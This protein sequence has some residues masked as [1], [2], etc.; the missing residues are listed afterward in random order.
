[1]H[2]RYRIA[3]VILPLAASFLSPAAPALAATAVPDLSISKVADP[4]PVGVGQTITYTITIVNPGPETVTGVEGLDFL[5]PEVDFVSAMDSVGSDCFHDGQFARC[6]IGSMPPGTITMT[7]VGTVTQ[8]PSDGSL[9]NFCTVF[10][11]N[12]PDPSNN[13]F[14][15]ETSVVETVLE[16]EK[17]DSEDPVEQGAELTYTITVRNVGTETAE[18]V[19][20]VDMLPDKVTFVAAAGC[21]SDGLPTVECEAGDMPPGSTAFFQVVVTVAPDATGTIENIVQAAGRNTNIAQASEPTTIGPCIPEGALTD[22]DIMEN[23]LDKMVEQQQ[24]GGGMTK[25][26]VKQNTKFVEGVKKDMLGE[27]FPDVFGA[28][29]DLVFIFLE[30][31]DTSME[32]ARRLADNQFHDVAKDF[33]RARARVRALRSMLEGS[34]APEGVFTDLDVMENKLDKMIRKQEQGDGMTKEKVKQ[35]TKFVEDVKE[36]MLGEHFSDVCGAPFDLVFIF[37]EQIDTAMER[38]RRLADNQFHDVAKDFE[39]ARARVRALRG[40]LE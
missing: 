40:L 37:L 14:E 16:I 7:V 35:N 21:N 23:K 26:K 24:R 29:F 38:A 30:Q 19:L 25:E 1:M 20:V 22:L 31:I 11:D 33:E 6:P 3:S 28:P 10:P 13:H 18:D 2:K 36:E 39:R 32:R 17:T 5:P 9:N 8:L 4:D 27:H 12:D 34:G 15:L